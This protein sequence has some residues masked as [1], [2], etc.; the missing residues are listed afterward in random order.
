ML[1]MCEFVGKA[2]F[3]GIITVFVKLHYM[4]IPF[5]FTPVSPQFSQECFDGES[6]SLRIY[7][8]EWVYIS[9]DLVFISKC[10]CL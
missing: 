1:V 8:C 3:I 6:R 7:N 5:Y 9:Q 10:I 2:D 4:Y